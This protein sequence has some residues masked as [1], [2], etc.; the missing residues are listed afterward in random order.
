MIMALTISILMAGG[1]YLVLQRGMYRLILGMSLIGHAGNLTILALGIPKWRAEPI[2]SP[3]ELAADPLPQAFVLTAIVIAMATTTFMLALSAVGYNDDTKSKRAAHV[4]LAPLITTAR[5][6]RPLP[7]DSAR[8]RRVQA[9]E[10]EAG[11]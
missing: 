2:N 5:N 1:V 11:Q 10:S 8:V 7:E 6:V 4:A 9:A 3:L